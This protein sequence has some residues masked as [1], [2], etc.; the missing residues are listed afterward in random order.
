MLAR[1]AACAA[2]VFAWPVWAGLDGGASP[3]PGIAVAMAQ[4]LAQKTP[5]QQAI[6]ASDQTV[7]VKDKTLGAQRQGIQVAMRPEGIRPAPTNKPSSP[8]SSVAPQALPFGLAAERVSEG[9]ILHKWTEEI[10]ASCREGASSCPP[11]AQV[12]L[13]IVDEAARAAVARAL[14]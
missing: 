1:V 13:A 14:E 4:E 5:Q 8:Q 6:A 3:Y 2:W 7:D 12:F 10:L 11:A 9:E